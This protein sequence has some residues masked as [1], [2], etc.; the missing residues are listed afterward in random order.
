MQFPSERVEKAVKA[1]TGLPGMGRKSA[2]RIVWH[3]LKQDPEATRLLVEALADL[4]ANIR[5]C[6]DCHNFSDFERCAVCENA[7]RDHSI[8][9]V[10]ATIPD[11][12]ALENTGH[13]R[14]IYHVLGGVIAP[15]EGIGPSDLT[16]ESLLNR[17]KSGEV[18]EVILA[19]P[20]TMEGET[21][22]LYLFKK[23]GE[24]QVKVTNIA[25]GVPVGSHLE[26]TDEV[27][28]LKSLLARTEM[29]R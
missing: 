9:C 24:S 21:T 22:G 16:V 27:T 12:L 2:F 20:S 18:K 8:I 14:G 29:I 11:L 1:V 3:L 26:Y 17:T 5:Y 15:A 25:R 4:R 23:L 10:V 6:A 7:N 28:I 19:L 13:Y